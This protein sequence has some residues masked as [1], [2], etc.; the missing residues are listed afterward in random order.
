MICKYQSYLLDIQDRQ[1]FFLILN[2]RFTIMEIM[3][4]STL[5]RIRKDKTE[6]VSPAENPNKDDGNFSMHQF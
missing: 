5:K 2:G 6:L 3:L 1:H 4:N